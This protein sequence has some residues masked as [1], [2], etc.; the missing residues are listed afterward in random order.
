MV[1]ATN[2]C[3]HS[4]SA[5]A[6]SNSFVCYCVLP[7]VFCCAGM[8]VSALIVCTYYQSEP[9]PSVINSKF[10]YQIKHKTTYVANCIVPATYVHINFD[11]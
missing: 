1:L 11:R 2:E 6:L 4:H 5:I 10:N 3:V 7:V 8:C 9:S